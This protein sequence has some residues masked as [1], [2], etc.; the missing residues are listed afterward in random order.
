MP[1][2]KLTTRA[3]YGNFDK[4]KKSHGSLQSGDYLK[5]TQI[6]VICIPLHLEMFN[7]HAMFKNHASGEERDGDPS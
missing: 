3:A 2:S 7:N 5:F 4:L 1:P 6:F